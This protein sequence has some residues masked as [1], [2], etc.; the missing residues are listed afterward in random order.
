MDKQFNL[1]VFIGDAEYLVTANDTRWEIF[2]MAN[3]EKQDLYA[4]M[5][6]KNLLTDDWEPTDSDRD[7]DNG[8][9]VATCFDNMTE[10]IKNIWNE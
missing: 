8:D 10:F 2:T 1:T 6:G 4:F 9:N 3:G 7:M 5:E